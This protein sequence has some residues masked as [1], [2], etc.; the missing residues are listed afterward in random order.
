[1]QIT[2]WLDRLAALP[3][4]EP[5][6]TR[7]ARAVGLHAQALH[8]L[9]S[10][11]LL[12][13]PTPGVYV[14]AEAPDTLEL[15]CR[16]LALVLPPDCFVCDRTAAWIHAGDRALG[17]NE[18]LEP[19]PVSCF[20]PSDGGRLRNALSASGERAVLPRDLM[21]L[22]GLVLTTPLRT[23]LDLGRLSRTSDLKLHGMDTMLGLGVF[24]HAELMAEVPRFRRQRGVVEL[25]V[26]APEADGGSESYGE[27][28]L[29]RRWRAAGL[30]RPRTQVPV[31]ADGR[32]IHRLDM[33]LEE[34]R[35]AAEYDGERWHGEERAEAD[36]E[37]RRWLSG[38]RGWLVEVFRRDHVFGHRQDA[39]QRLAAAYETVR[40][41]RRLGPRV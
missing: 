21:E 23:A 40:A 35:L 29:R 17:P 30:P 15:R 34:L 16:A 25:R 37:R 4:G 38:E 7:A 18:H 33:G 20:R 14:A 41:R 31:V 11:G 32:E 1:M 5:F 9:T 19:P 13:H 6:T 26:L 12:R 22:D 8:R 2:S 3:A 36:A 24:T 10:D 27:S 28:A 39:E